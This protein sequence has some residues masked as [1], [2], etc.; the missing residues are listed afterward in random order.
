MERKKKICGVKFCGGCNPRYDRGAAY[1]EVLSRLSHVLDFHLAE[2][3]QTYDLLFVVCGCTSC[4]ATLAAYS[5]REATVK[6]WEEEQLEDCILQ[7]GA[8]ARRLI[9][10][11]SHL[12]Q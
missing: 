8:L 2:E 5:V 11:N 6:L 7:L 4:C 1:Q 12:S 10:K 3:G 9:K